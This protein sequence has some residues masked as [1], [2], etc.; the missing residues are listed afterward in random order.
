MIF[1]FGLVNK[2]PTS[3]PPQLQGTVYNIFV[4]SPNALF[5]KEITEH[6]PW[7]CLQHRLPNE[8]IAVLSRNNNRTRKVGLGVLSKVADD[9]KM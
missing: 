4:I 8:R 5:Y 1:D 9:T 6:Y 3:Y 7:F 2:K